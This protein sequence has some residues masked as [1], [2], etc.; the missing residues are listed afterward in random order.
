MS[1]LKVCFFDY[2]YCL[3]Q[4]NIYFKT[5]CFRGDVRVE[6]FF[7][8]KNSFSCDLYVIAHIIDLMSEHVSR[9]NHNES[10]QLCIQY[11]TIAANHR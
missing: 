7:Q 3:R 8:Q 4:R 10:R 9:Q 1:S 6:I 2:V 11:V 5:H